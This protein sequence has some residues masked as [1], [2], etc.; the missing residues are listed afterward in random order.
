MSNECCILYVYH[1]D[2]L[3]PT[4]RPGDPR[5][6]DKR[7]QKHYASLVADNPGVPVVPLVCGY[8]PCIDGTIDIEQRPNLWKPYTQATKNDTL[9]AHNDSILW[10]YLSGDHIEA[11]RYIFFDWDTLSQG[12]SVREFYNDVW[13]N[14]D[15]A[16]ILLCRWPNPTTWIWWAGLDKKLPTQHICGLC[17]FCGTFFRHDAAMYLS[18]TDPE[19]IYP[20]FVNVGCEVRPITMLS[21]AGFTLAGIPHREVMLGTYGGRCRYSTERGIYHPI[22]NDVEAGEVPIPYVPPITKPEKNCEDCLPMSNLWTPTP[23]SERPIVLPGP[24][25]RPRRV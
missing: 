3:Y 7:I 18:A 22:T 10:R 19:S 16:G 20:G 5:C 2:R 21:L 24:R 4:D 8:R 14:V 1:T 25:L 11:D 23:S 17:P 12:M 15:A 6:S 13:D 9:W